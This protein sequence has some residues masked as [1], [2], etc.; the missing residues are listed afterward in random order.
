MKV[1]HVTNEEIIEAALFYK[2]TAQ[3]AYSAIRE[4]RKPLNLARRMKLDSIIKE[5]K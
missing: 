4:D 5:S 3:Q 2:V 1:H